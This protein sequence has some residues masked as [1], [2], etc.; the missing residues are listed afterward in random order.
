MILGV[1]WYYGFPSGLYNF[2]YFVFRKGVGGHGDG[3]AQLETS[4]VANDADKLVNRLDDLI[5]K[6][7]QAFLFVSRD[8][9]ILTISINN[10]YLFDYDFLIAKEVETILHNEQVLFNS[11]RE[12]IN[13]K[14][15]RLENKLPQLA[16]PSKD[17]FQ[18]VSSHLGQYNAEALSLRLD[19]NLNAADKHEFIE[20]LDDL[21]SRLNIEILY[22][23]ENIFLNKSNLMLFFS[24]G[25]Q[26]LNFHEKRIVDVQLLEESI[27][28]LFN[29]FSVQKGHVGGFEAY[30]TGEP[31]VRKALHW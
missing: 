25:R 7:K 24:N 3:P 18:I 15:L 26:G 27:A 20:S 17:F 5:K 19:C 1:Y 4:I 2:D 16:Y 29:Q 11:N 8:N 9:N 14:W 12:L 13:P 30:P 23:Y 28:E 21:T 6:H 22:Y 31:I 10:Y